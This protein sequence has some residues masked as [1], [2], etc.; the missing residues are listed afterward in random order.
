MLCVVISPYLEKGFFTDFWVTV[1]LSTAAQP[2]YNQ[3]MSRLLQI[4]VL[5]YVMCGLLK[6]KSIMLDE[7]TY[8][9]EFYHIFGPNYKQKLGHSLDRKHSNTYL[10]QNEK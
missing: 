9:T 10:A 4:L 1:D 2:P 6:N 3:Y 7:I 8:T 5:L